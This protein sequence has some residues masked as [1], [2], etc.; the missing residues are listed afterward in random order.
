LGGGYIAPSSSTASCELYDP[1]SNSWLP[2]GPLKEAR[3]APFAVVLGD[4]SVLVVGGAN[5]NKILASSERWQVPLHR[6]KELTAKEADAKTTATPAAKTE[7]TAPPPYGASYKAFLAGL[8]DLLAQRAWPLARRSVAQALFK[9]AELA[10]YAQALKLDLECVALAEQAHLAV[11]KGAALLA[12]G[13]AFT[14]EQVD[15]KP[16]AIG[17]GSK[18]VVKKVT[19]DAIYIEQDI[20]GG[21]VYV[22][23]PLAQL[24]AST[25]LELAYLGLPPGG[26]RKLALAL[27]KFAQISGKDAARSEKEFLALLDQAAKEG[28][29]PEKVAHLRGW[30]VTKQKQ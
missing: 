27:M 20:G 9:D 5:G 10:P 28:A 2:T 4:G 19:N 16:I 29:A 23:V 13:R 26:D 7:A 18:T 22:G 1:V 17:Q 14:L 30:I 3:R 24:S 15:G 21:K 8:Q 11:P 25:I 6:A 12:D